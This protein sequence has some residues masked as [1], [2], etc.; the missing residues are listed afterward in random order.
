MRDLMQF[1]PYK[2]HA[3]FCYFCRSLPLLI[4][5]LC[6]NGV[7]IGG[8]QVAGVVDALHEAV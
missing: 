1:F 2:L 4:V 3:S 6:F 7:G 5:A 8:E